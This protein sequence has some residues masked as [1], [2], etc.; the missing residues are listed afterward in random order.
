MKIGR[1]FESGRET[2]GFVKDDRVATREEITYETGVPL[3]FIIKD[4]LFDGWYDEIMKKILNYLLMKN[5]LNIQFLLLF[6]ILQKLFV[7]HSITLTMQKNK[8]KNHQK[9]QCL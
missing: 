4:F 1:F 9:I 8:E 6:R 5:Y 2:F 3:P 7:L